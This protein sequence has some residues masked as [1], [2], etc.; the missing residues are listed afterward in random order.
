VESEASAVGVERLYLYTPSAAD[1][2][3]RLGWTIEDRCE[4]LGQEVTVMSRPVAAD[5]G[6]TE[7][8]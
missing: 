8:G 4:Y 3:G 1:F 5:A 7:P 2:Y 6:R